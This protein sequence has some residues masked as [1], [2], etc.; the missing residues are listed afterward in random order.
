MDDSKLEAK[1]DKMTDHLS[2]IDVTLA[3]QAVSLDVHIRRTEL[4]EAELKPIKKHVDMV[5]GGIK[6]LSVIGIVYE[7]YRALK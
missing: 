2:A 5:N 1:L 7:L 3:K 4:L 6:L